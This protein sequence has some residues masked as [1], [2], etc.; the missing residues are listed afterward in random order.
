MHQELSALRSQVDTRSRVR[1][2][3]P[4]TLLPDRFGKKNGPSWT[5]WSYL[6]GDFVGV[7]HATL[8]LAM[9][10]AENQKQPISVTHL[11][12]KF[13]VTNEMDQ[14]LQPFLILRTEGE[15]LE[16]V[17][18]AEREPGLEQWRRLG[19]LYDP[20][21]A[22]RSLD[23]SRQILSPPKAAK[24]DDLSHTIPAWGNLEQRHRE[25]TRDQLPK[26][27]RLAVLLSMCP[28]NLEKE[29]TTHQHL[30]PDH[31]HMKTHIVTVINSRTRGLAPIMMGNLSD[32]DSNHHASSDESVESEDGE[33]CRLE[34]R[35]GKKVFTKS[36]HESSKGKGGGKG[37][38]DRECFP[39]WTHWPHQSGS[40][41]QN[42]H[43][44]ETPKSAPK[45][46]SVGSCEGDHRFGG[47][48]TCCQT[49]VLRRTAM[50]PHL[51]SQKQCH[52]CHL[53][54]GSR[55][56]RR[57]AESFGKLAMKI[58]E[59][60]KIHSLIVGWEARTV[61]RIATNG[62]MGTKRTEVCSRCERLPLS[63]LP[64]LFC[65]PEDGSVPT[66]ANLK[67]HSPISP[68][69]EQ[70]DRATT[71]MMETGGLTRWT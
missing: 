55:G 1:L 8:K 33:L 23:D 14:E 12:H 4:K 19:A 26:D 63:E 7:V 45:G 24:I 52:H 53:I 29:M 40:Q 67:R 43:Q 38:T 34:I 16:I 25:R 20:S 69:K 71:P 44:W 57:F 47:P 22:G 36:R 3:E 32:E 56:Q 35:N 58:T 13:N 68:V 30:F 11:Q 66:S 61:R 21:A 28:T 64:C 42:S 41:S 5:T 15:A 17:R 6:A 70:T 46:K 59:T 48:L 51:R 50:N 10:A 54:P 39:L 2:V 18:G 37:K 60:K 49:T 62:S 27:M 65:V 9:K 31:A